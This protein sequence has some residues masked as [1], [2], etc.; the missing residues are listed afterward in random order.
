MGAVV[1]TSKLDSSYDQE[2]AIQAIIEAFTTLGEGSETQ[3]VVAYGD[4]S[5]TIFMVGPSLAQLFKRLVGDCLREKRRVDFCFGLKI[6]GIGVAGAA[7]FLDAESDAG[8][9]TGIWGSS[10]E[11]VAFVENLVR[12]IEEGSEGNDGFIVAHRIQA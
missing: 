12:T 9:F 1:L 3:Y 10:M 4:N 8:S 5:S 11:A 7:G 2:R 6:P